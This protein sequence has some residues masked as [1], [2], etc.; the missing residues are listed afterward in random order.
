MTAKKSQFDVAGIG[1]AIVD[2]LAHADDIFLEDNGLN[3]GAMTLIDA[4]RAAELYEAM[5]PAMEVS[6]GSAANTLVALAS[7][8]G[9]GAF[10]GKVRNDQLG[11]IF[12]H[13]IQAA[14]VAFDTPAASSGPPTARCLIFVTPDAQRTM[15]TY[16]GACV[17]LSPGDIDEKMVAAAKVTYLEGYLWD[18]PQAK[19]AFLKAAEIAHKAGRKVA[20]SLSDPFCVE[21]HRSEF[22]D[23]V[24]KHVDILFANEHEIQS[25][26]ETELFR[27]RVSTCARDVRRRGAD[28]KREGLGDRKRRGG[29]HHRRH[30]DGRGGRQHRCGGRLRRGISLRSDPGIRSCPLRPPGKS[31]RRRNHQPF[32]RPAGKLAGRTR[33]GAFAVNG[34]RSRAF[35]MPKNLIGRWASAAAV[36]KDRR[37]LA[38]LLMG[39]SSGLPLALVGATLGVRLAEEQVSLTTIGFFALTGIAYNIKFLW[40][41]VMDRSPFPF[42]TRQFGRR[43]GWALAT[44]AALIAAIIFLGNSDPFSSAGLTA[45]AAVLVAFCSASQDIVIDA[46]RVD[47]LAENE[48]GAGAAATQFGWRIGALVSGAGAL[49]A[50]SFG[51]WRFAY[52]LMAAFVLIGVAAVLSVAE[53]ARGQD[54]L[55]KHARGF[56]EWLQHA[57]IDPFADFM[58]RHPYVP[59]LIF[60]VLY[61]FG[62]ALTGVMSSPFYVAMGFTKI[63][64][65]NI[66]KIFGTIATVLGVF[67]GGSLVYR[68]GALRSLLICGVA[69]MLSNA[70]FAVQAMAGHNPALLILDDRC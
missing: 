57:V 30:A 38:I 26:F 44:Q 22:R 41:P 54:E 66:S 62:D 7:L 60:V 10:I 67:F 25:L 65:A 9:H 18:P 45:L 49:Y 42:L 13:D 70:M 28:A 3:K 61:K 19:Q 20:L 64:I 52:D 32:R 23:L 17:D 48:Q 5:G 34:S 58:S 16:L 37:I 50:A 21:R 2:V 56:G 53:P 29:P 47:L 46:L 59:I 40:A 68:L 69:Q 51:G 24:A 15:Q 6:G 27:R 12:R 43:R 11:G 39:F 14:G 1:N 63:E 31:C 4:A 35:G 36:Y 8:G 33:G 55:T